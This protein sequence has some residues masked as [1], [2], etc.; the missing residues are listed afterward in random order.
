MIA[1]I[2]IGVGIGLTLGALGAGGA[3]LAVPA[4]VYGAGQPLDVAIPM[5]LSVVAV[6]SLGALLPGR[7]RAAVRWRIAFA[8][9]AAGVPAT[10]GGAALGRLLP[11]RWL[12]LAF[13]GL[14]VAVAVRMLR[15]G[16][17]GG[18]G[19]DGGEDHAG[20]C[21]ASGEKVNW[22]RCLPKVVLAGAAV[23]VLTGLFGVGGGF[24][25]VPALGLLLGLTPQQAVATSLVV[26]AAN[27]LSGL[28]A[29]ADAISEIDPAVFVPFGIATLVAAIAAGG[30]ASRLAGRIVRTA[31]A[32]VVL[33]VA[34]FVAVAAIVAPQALG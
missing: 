32:V 31:F 7:R 5:S 9:A 4:L 28:V 14:M 29:H 34:A 10:F 22:R 17:E 30:L 25:V 18:D 8:F 19:D 16:G 33:G 20:A 23:G 27:S 12:L 2:G 6:A 1:A 3:I 24:V 21:R 13:A 15:G 11:Q 26:V